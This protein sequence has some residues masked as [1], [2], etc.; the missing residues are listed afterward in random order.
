MNR[1]MDEWM[2]WDELRWD[3]ATR[4]EKIRKDIKV[5]EEMENKRIN[6]NICPFH[7]NLIVEMF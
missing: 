6:L 3:A 2:R 7:P 4:N 1:W 5:N